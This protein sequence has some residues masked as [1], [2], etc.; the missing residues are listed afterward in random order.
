[1]KRMS[2]WALAVLFVCACEMPPGAAP[3]PF[4]LA[5]V[6][7]FDGAPPDG[8]MG[9]GLDGN[10][11]PLD[12]GTGL[13]SLWFTVTD[14][15]TQL[16]MPA[17]VIFRPPP[18]AGFAD[19]IT[20]GTWNVNSPGS[21]T[22][23]VVAPGVVG[24]PEGVL[25]VSGQ[26]VV[27][28]PA[29][30]YDLF[31]TRGPE[32]EAVDAH[33]V[34]AP[35]AVQAV[36]A[37]LWR[38]VDTRGWLASDMHVH[39][40]AS[41]DSK[42][43]LD[44]RIVSMTTSGVEVIVSTDHNVHSDLAPEIAALGYG[45]DVVGSVVGNEFNFRAGHGGAFPVPYDA[46]KLYGGAPMY[47][48]YNPATN[49][50]DAPVYGIN[51]YS[52]TESFMR[53]RALI[54]GDTIIQINHPW[55]AGA[56]L[57]YFTNINWGA[58]T[59][60]GF[61]PLESVGLFESIEVLNGYWTRG[62]VESDLMLDWMWL[63]GQ[64]LRVTA[65]GNSDT[66]KINWVRGG[67]PRTWLRL[68]NDKPGD[69]TGAALAD[70]VRHQRAIAS[71]GPFAVFTV[72]GAQIGDTVVPAAAGKVHVAITVDAPAWMSVDTVRVY[73]NGVVAK[74][75]SVPAG[76]QRPVFAAAY[77]EPIAGDSWI[78]VVASGSQPLPADVVGEYSHANGYEMTP[79][80][81]ANPVFVDANGDGVVQP[82][83]TPTP[84]PPPHAPPGPLRRA[85]NVPVECEPFGQH[86][87]ELPPPVQQL[88]PLL[89]QQ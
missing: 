38:T 85:L 2:R 34:I 80:A 77:D 7:T 42:L 78:A 11:L 13:A 89:Y 62:D 18:G 73:K 67:F 69:T 47:Q 51:C 20:S 35:G 56:D 9:T 81:I 17:R 19:S 57:G 86:G 10:Q 55:W 79:I 14:G 49:M 46:T 12:G 74:T 71:T 50:C 33:V 4:D 28:V 58:A 43:P 59:P 30:T 32:W 6:V 29:G 27:P 66:H 31:I 15:D 37:T 8:W 82:P 26:G 64:G 5:N 63:L 3:S 24:A 53:M 84:A 54:P 22:G 45:T 88:M 40:G 72:D 21:G 48:S 41:F 68:A 1:M 83:A 76:G 65:V 39:T 16:P 70:A 25:L 87:E 60:G 75:W 36:N 61:G 23:A 52:N 44:R